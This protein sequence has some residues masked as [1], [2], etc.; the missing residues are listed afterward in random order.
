M[1]VY[2]LLFSSN[3]HHETFTQVDSFC[4][5]GLLPATQLSLSCAGLSVTLHNQLERAGQELTGQLA[6]L[7]L[8]PAFPRDQAVARAHLAAL[9]AGL[10]LWPGGTTHASI[11]VR[12]PSDPTSYQMHLKC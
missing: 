12:F 7:S 6:G 2:T 5:P 10:Q 11:Q 1:V 8:H 4:H 3:P 9:T